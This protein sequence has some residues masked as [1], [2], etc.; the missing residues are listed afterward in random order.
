MFYNYEF[1]MKYYSIEQELLEKIKM[2]EKEYSE[3]EVKT[4]CEY[5]YRKEFLDI[6]QLESFED[7]LMNEKMSYLWEK[8]K[9]NPEFKEIFKCYQMQYFRKY[10]EKKNKE[11]FY[12]LFSFDLL[13]FTHSCI[14]SLFIHNMVETEKKELLIN[15]IRILH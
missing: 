9:E 1:E 5:L 10:N 4:I 15:Q 6:F 14:R 3:E 11:L 7:C 8:V 12:T 2:G 13:A